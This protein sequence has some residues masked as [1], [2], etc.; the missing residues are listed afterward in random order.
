MVVTLM[1]FVGC[2]MVVT[3]MLF[4]GG[5]MIMT[6]MGLFRLGGL[7]LL[8]CQLA[9]GC[10]GY[11]KQG[12]RL[13]ELGEGLGILRLLLGRR[14]GVLKTDQIG[15]RGLQLNHQL[16]AIDDKVEQ[17]VA[18]FMSAMAMALAMFMIGLNAKG[19]RSQ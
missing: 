12:L 10:R 18:M 4:V 14:G 16:I 3:L 7:D 15:G 8:M 11:P 1:L 9:R 17:A 13:L 6:F 2:I 5:I 19:G